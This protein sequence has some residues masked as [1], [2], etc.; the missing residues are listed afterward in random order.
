MKSKLKMIIRDFMGHCHHKFYTD[1][2]W[3]HFEY[4]TF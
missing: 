2:V 3:Y 4:Q 1:A